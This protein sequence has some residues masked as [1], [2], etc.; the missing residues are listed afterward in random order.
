[1]KLE[2]NRKKNILNLKNAEVFYLKTGITR[3]ALTL[4]LALSV[5]IGSSLGLQMLNGYALG[6]SGSPNPTVYCTITNLNGNSLTA[7]ANGYTFDSTYPRLVTNGNRI[8]AT[9]Y[10]YDSEGVTS[11]NLKLIKVLETNNLLHWEQPGWP[12]LL[13][14][15]NFT[16]SNYEI[17]QHE[18]NITAPGTYAVLATTTVNGRE[19]KTHK[20]FLYGPGTIVGGDFFT[21]IDRP[22]GQ[23]LFCTLYDL[24]GNGID[25]TSLYVTK[26]AGGPSYVSN[27]RLTVSQDPSF[28]RRYRVEGYGYR[29]ANLSNIPGQYLGYLEVYPNS[30][31]IPD[32][33]YYPPFN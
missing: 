16:A 33:I 8:R 30:F 32:R 19:S 1:M 21:R 28:S 3:R 25:S 24:G 23:S 12:E 5:I 7:S 18:F 14:E 15:G 29:N 6:V 17:K 31:R 22:E 20:F 4:L 10:A 13:Y 26:V 11:I 27:N 2:T 9:F